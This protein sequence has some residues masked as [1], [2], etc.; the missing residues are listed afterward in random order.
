MIFINIHGVPKK[1]FVKNLI[2][3]IKFITINDSKKAS[4]FISAKD[5]THKVLKSL[6]EHTM[7]NAD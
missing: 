2:K 6:V 3:D 1:I 5:V 7:L 4:Y